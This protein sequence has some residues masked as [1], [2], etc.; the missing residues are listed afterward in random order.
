VILSCDVDAQPPRKSA[1]SAAEVLNRTR[2]L[3]DDEAA[4]VVMAGPW[5][6]I[7]APGL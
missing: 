6:R 1:R 3:N 2:L 4:E 7:P 5:I